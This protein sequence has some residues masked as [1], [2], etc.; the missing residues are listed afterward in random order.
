MWS[1][2]DLRPRA[3]RFLASLWDRILHPLWL[4][5]WAV[6]SVFV[7]LQDILRELWGESGRKR[8]WRW[9]KRTSWWILPGTISNRC[10][11][12]SSGLAVSSFTWH[13]C[14]GMQPWKKRSGGNQILKW[15][16]YN[17]VLH[18]L[19]CYVSSFL[20]SFLCSICLNFSSPS[21]PCSLT[22][23]LSFLPSLLP[24]TPLLTPLKF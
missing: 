24:I 12:G 18:S 13:P 19:P 3:Q 15:Y 17:F 22:C 11:P 8:C 6:K 21:H 1:V 16:R 10:L 20:Q 7:R 9:G 5:Q 14:R 23:P 4:E 2:S